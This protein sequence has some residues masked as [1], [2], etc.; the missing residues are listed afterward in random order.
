MTVLAVIAFDVFESRRQE[1]M[2]NLCRY[3]HEI[4]YVDTKIIEKDI[5]KEII[6]RESWNNEIVHVGKLH[7]SIEIW[8]D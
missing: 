8:L 1:I 3:V 2:K 4:L 6:I 7:S 5:C